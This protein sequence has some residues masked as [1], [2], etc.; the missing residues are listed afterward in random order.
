MALGHEDVLAQCSEAAAEVPAE[1]DLAQLAVGKPMPTE[2][3]DACLVMPD[4]DQST[5]V[6]LADKSLCTGSCLGSTKR[7]R[8]TSSS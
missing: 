2:I 6:D 7:G 5:L 1:A 8:S 3:D 4:P